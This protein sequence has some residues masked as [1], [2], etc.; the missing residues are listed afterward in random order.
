[1]AFLSDD[2]CLS[3]CE[4]R[5]DAGDRSL[6]DYKFMCF[7][8]KPD[9]L[10][11]CT[12]RETGD[13]KFLFFDEKWHL[14]RYNARSLS[15]PSGYS[16]EPPPMLGEMFDLAKTLS[17]GVSFVRVDLYCVGSRIQFGEMTF[18]PQ[19]GF[20]ANILPDADLRWGGM[21]DLPKTD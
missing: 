20:D 6:A 3:L 1:M 19:S 15:L 13:P 10:M 8:G 11:L 4:G 18:F 7:G 16:V 21:L 5:P 2:A 17:C 12:E 9:C 14:M